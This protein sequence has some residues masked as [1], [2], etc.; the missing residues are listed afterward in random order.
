MAEI[1]AEEHA[2][3]REL[4]HLLET[5]QGAEEKQLLKGS[6]LNMKSSGLRNRITDII[7]LDVDIN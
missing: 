2:E 5:L 1:S 7:C 4:K 6:R 3:V